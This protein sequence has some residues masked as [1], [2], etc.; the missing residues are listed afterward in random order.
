MGF[1]Q[2]LGYF[3]ASMVV[4]KFIMLGIGMLMQK[5]MFYKFEK[6]IKAG[7]IQFM[8]PEQLAELGLTEDTE[9]KTWQ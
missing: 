5:Y 3:L 7:K 4:Y 9:N 1:L 2:F 6:D 8:T